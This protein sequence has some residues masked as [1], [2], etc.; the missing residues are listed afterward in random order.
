[1]WLLC[2]FFLSW[3]PFRVTLRNGQITIVTLALVL[4]AFAA[5]TRKKDLLAGLL[6]GLS[7]WKYPLTFPFPLYFMWKREWKLVFTSL[8]VPLVLTEVYAWRLGVTVA[9]V[10]REYGSR[11]G[12]LSLGNSSFLEGSTDL[13]PLIAA[14]TGLTEPVPAVITGA[15]CVIAIAAMAVVFRRTRSC[16]LL[17]FSVL[18]LFSLWAVYHRS[19]DAVICLIPAAALITWLG[20]R[21]A[22]WA[23]LAGLALLAS[24]VVGVHGLITSRLSFLAD[25]WPGVLA[26]HAERLIVF[27]LFWLFVWI[28]WRRRAS[29]HDSR[30]STISG[31]PA[32]A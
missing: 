14:I 32:D 6:L 23:A 20:R 5:R 8:A 3:A 26:V 17:H 28:L 27:G 31:C 18:A 2:A 9:D 25:H 15:I 7:L 16:E 30:S 24:L 21:E 19:Y 29:P 13:K 4:G 1:R 11:I 12:E 10:V 22:A